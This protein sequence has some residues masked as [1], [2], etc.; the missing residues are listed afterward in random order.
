MTPE[1][2]LER[3]WTHRTSAIIRTGEQ[4]VAA[5]AMDAAVAGG[6]RIVE[7]T[8]TTPGAIELIAEFSRK[9]VEPEQGIDDLVVGAGTVLTRK[10]ALAALD[11]GARFLVSPVFDEAIV[12]LAVERGAVAMPGTHTPTEMLAA[13]RAGAQLLKLFPAPAGGPAWLRSVLAP[14]PFARVVPTNGVD[15][16][17]IAQWLQA[18]AWGVGLVAPLFRPDD[19]A[20]SNFSAVS[21]RARQMRE[22]AMA[23]E[24]GPVPQ[25]R[26]PFA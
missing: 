21:A 8:L 19:L 20:T 6:I 17:N 7:F 13:H 1:Q 2:L 24:R 4:E 18:G 5:R 11:A 10:D 25:V 23:L 15:E 9:K 14:M 22:A 26:D 16:S 3:V 12:R